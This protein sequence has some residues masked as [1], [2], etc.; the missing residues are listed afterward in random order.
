MT[1]AI[2]TGLAQLPSLFRSLAVVGPEHPLKYTGYFA[3]LAVP[4]AVVGPE[5]PLKYTA[6]VQARAPWAAVVGPEHPLKYTL[7]FSLRV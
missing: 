5:H 7:P 4:Y 2:E 1:L 6:L 3:A